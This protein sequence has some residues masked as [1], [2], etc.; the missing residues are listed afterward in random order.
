M[1]AR[2]VFGL[3]VRVCGLILGYQVAFG[4]YSHLASLM[5]PTT[6]VRYVVPDLFTAL[7][8]LAVSIYLLKGAPGLVR[9]CYRDES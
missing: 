5:S 9:F 4:I 7:V 3:V 2:D 6:P 1:K 8:P